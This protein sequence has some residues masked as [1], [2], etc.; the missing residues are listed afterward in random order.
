[1]T[2][3]YLLLVVAAAALLSACGDDVPKVEDPHHIVV[4]GNTMKPMEFIKKYCEGKT[5]HE[6]CIKV[7][8]AMLQD[9]T[10]GNPARF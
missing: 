10:K 2:K 7:Q 1:M 6:T 9:S 8:R 4:N 5:G 3:K